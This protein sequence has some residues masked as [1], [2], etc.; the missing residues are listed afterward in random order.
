MI[1]ILH[2]GHDTESVAG[3]IYNPWA[4]LLLATGRVAATHDGKTPRGN[5]DDV[6]QIQVYC[7]GSTNMLWFGGRF[8][9]HDKLLSLMEDKGIDVGDTIWIRAC[10]VGDNFLLSLARDSGRRV[11]GFTHKVHAFQGRLKGFDRNG[12]RLTPDDGL[13]SVN[14]W[15]MPWHPRTIPAT[16]VK[17]PERFLNAH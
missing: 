3:K 13:D 10:S 14:Q 16:Q 17:L 11:F 15:S 1:G 12:K 4:G 5:W 8:L 9:S 6:S 2:D 7:H